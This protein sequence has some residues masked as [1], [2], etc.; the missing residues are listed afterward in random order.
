MY[1]RVVSVLYLL[2]GLCFCRCWLPQVIG[3]EILI[4]VWTLH[5]TSE[6]RWDPSVGL[7]R[8]LSRVFFRCC[9]SLFAG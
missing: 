7:G 5:R 1:V 3:Q 8:S 9:L 4:S 6:S 2:A